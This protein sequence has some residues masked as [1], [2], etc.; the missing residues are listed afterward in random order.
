ML[1]IGWPNVPSLSGKIISGEVA[2]TSADFR[3]YA[4][5]KT[6]VVS[7]ILKKVE[8]LRTKSVAQRYAVLVDKLKSTL[9]PY[10][11]QVLGYSL[12]KSLI[13]SIDGKQIVVYR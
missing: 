8:L 11:G 6:P 5:I 10:G 13:I 12:R 1:R 7:V 9:E 4:Q 2:L 3:T